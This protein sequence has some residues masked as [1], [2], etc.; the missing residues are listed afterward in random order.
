L[1][2]NSVRG[3]TVI[4][5]PIRKALGITPATQLH[6]TIKD[7]VIIVLP[8]P[9]DPSRRGYSQGMGTNFYGPAGL[10][11]CLCV[12]AM[13]VT[14]SLTPVPVSGLTSGVSAIAAGWKHTCA[15]TTGGGV[16]CWG[17]NYDGQLGNGTVWSATPVD[18]VES[19][20][21]PLILR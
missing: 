15:L 19:L 16:Q 13:T 3:Q 5:R 7:G 20:Y 21:L 17:N 11:E 8:I 2:A 1:G 18:V 10:G 9:A 6:W 4:P 14:D 12:L